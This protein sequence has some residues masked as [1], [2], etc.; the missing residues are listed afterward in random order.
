MF[1]VHCTGSCGRGHGTS[2]KTT[3]Q[4]IGKKSSGMRE[5]H[6]VTFL[7]KQTVSKT[8]QNGKPAFA[9]G[10]EVIKHPI[11]LRHRDSLDQSQFKHETLSSSRK[12]IKT[13]DIHHGDR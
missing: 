7:M 1:R 4:G 11:Q 3:Q 6:S 10:I 2:D 8:L 5:F 12:V 13:L 9:F